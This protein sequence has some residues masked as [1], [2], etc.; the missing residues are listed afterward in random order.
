M[1]CK[2]SLV[3]TRGNM[4]DMP[5][6]IRAVALDIAEALNN[7]SHA[8]ILHKLKSWNFW[9]GPLDAKLLQNCHINAGQF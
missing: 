2:N 3:A 5:S 1:T 4:S 6:A 7:F 8:V 9:S